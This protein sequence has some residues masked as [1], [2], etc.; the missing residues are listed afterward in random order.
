MSSVTVL[1]GAG[2]D[3]A[4]EIRDAGLLGMITLRGDLASPTLNAAVKTATGTA[5]PEMGQIVH[6]D[7]Q[8]CA[9]MSPDEL[10]IFA[11]YAQA[12]EITAQITGDLADHHALAVNVSDARAVFDLSGNA[13]RDVLSKGTPVDLSPDALGLNVVRRTRLGQVAVAFWFTSETTARLVCFRS[14]GA[15]ML[16]WLSTAA[17]PAAQVDYH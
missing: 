11:P 1:Q 16:T 8:S 7:A 14:V 13:I 17:D 12:D 3:G 2:F 6:A 15:Y 10:M 5:P 4:I 9:W